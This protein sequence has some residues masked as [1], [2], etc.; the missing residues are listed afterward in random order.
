[1]F[2]IDGKSTKENGWCLTPD[3]QKLTITFGHLFAT[4][5]G[6]AYKDLL[7]QLASIRVVHDRSTHW[8]YLLGKALKEA[9]PAEKPEEDYEI[10]EIAPF[11]VKYC[12]ALQGRECVAVEG[13][14]ASAD[15]SAEIIEGVKPNTEAVSS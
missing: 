2:Q 9:I 6:Q 12:S 1:M 4:Y 11:L 3:N 8:V 15:P 7:A 5:E 14:S 13:K 10:S